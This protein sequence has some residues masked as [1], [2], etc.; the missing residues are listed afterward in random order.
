MMWMLYLIQNLSI[1]IA[2]SFKKSTSNDEPDRSYP[3]FE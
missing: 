3:E 2:H 1:E